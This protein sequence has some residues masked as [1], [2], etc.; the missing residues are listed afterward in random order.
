MSNSKN[1]LPYISKV[2]SPIVMND[3][4]DKGYS[5]YL[6]E[7][8]INS[9]IYKEVDKSM[10]F[11]QGLNW[12]YNL[13]F[14]NYRNEYIYKNVIANKILLGKHSL[15]TSFMLSEFR[16][17]NCKADVVI[18]NGTSTVYEIKSEYDSFKRLNKQLEA[19]LEIFD[20]IN[21]ITSQ[22]QLEKLKMILPEKVGIL[23]LTDKN[24]ISTFR[25]P[26]SNKKYILPDKLFDSLRKNE[27]MLAI[28]R[29]YDYIPEV[30]NTQLYKVCKDLFNKIN[31]IQAH[32]LAYDILRNRCEADELKKL[33]NKSPISL[34]A[35]IMSISNEK[36]KLQKLLSL[37]N[38][39]FY[40]ILFQNV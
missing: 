10:T 2:F 8:F 7:I 35:Y 28:K 16:A 6:S 31:P 33:I 4:I 24:N 25:E 14:K 36:K 11:S 23:I 5:R 9:E 1:Y 22:S 32:D 39:N 18:I 3:I 30:P 21:I 34:R 38:C 20:F 27:Y 40:S 29:Y 13:L 37:L 15:N 26:I 17:S 19:Y 12:I